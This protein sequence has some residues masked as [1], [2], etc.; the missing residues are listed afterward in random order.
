MLPQGETIHVERDGGGVRSILMRKP[1]DFHNHFRAG[2]LRDA[3]TPEVSWPYKYV[4]AM[5]NTSPPLVTP[6]QAISY[7]EEITAILAQNGNI[8]TQLVLTIYLTAETTPETIRNLATFGL[9]MAVKS[10][11]PNGTTNSG[12]AV[13]I[14]SKPEVLKEMER[15]GVRL[16]IHGECTH[17]MEG[18]PIPHPLREAYFMLHI[19]PEVR[20]QYPNLLICLE[21]ITTIEAVEAVKRDPT[22]KT[23]CTITP[24]HGLLND[25]AFD[26]IW[27]GVNARCMP[28][29]KSE[30][31]R[32]A[33]VEFMTSGDARA[34]LGTD[35]APHLWSAKNKPFEEAAC[36]CYTPHALAMYV[37]IFEDAGCLDDRFIAFAC[38]NGPDWW[39]L[40]RP[41]ANET[42]RLE[43]DFD[44][45]I[46]E[47]TP[48]PAENDVVVP[49]GWTPEQHERLRLGFALD[50]THC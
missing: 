35:C 42:I 43:R 34:I 46:P 45:D 18:N 1:S 38:F 37:K 10:Y 7:G 14:L 9:R 6:A 39:G 11:P 3:I 22:G 4:L 40:P 49:L 13:P 5:P 47:P 27:G 16:L 20:K 28:Y 29:L 30:A 15:L 23:V 33:I 24:Q 36:G 32:R 25:S 8:S 41:Q 26:E 50:H 44:R 12:H 21:H 19:F 2:D 17:N 31:N 48:V